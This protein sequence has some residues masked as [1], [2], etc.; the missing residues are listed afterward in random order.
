MLTDARLRALIAVTPDRRIELPDGSIK[1]LILRAGPRA[2]PTWTLRYAVAGAGGVTA[3]GK[4]L[5][6]R[7]FFRI[8]LGTYPTVSLKEARAKASAFLAKA[9]RGEDPLAQI[10]DIATTQKDSVCELA[11][12]FL[13]L[14]VRGRL[15]SAKNTEWVMRE[16]VLPRLGQVRADKLK[17]TDIV[18][19]LNDLARHATPTAAIETR[20]WLSSLFSWSLEK[21]RIATNPLLGVRAPVKS[22]QRERVLS[23]DEARA[24]WRAA[25]AEGYPSGTLVCLLMLTSARLRE[26]A[27]ARLAWLD[28]SQACL[29][30]PGE[31]YKTG[32]A[33]IVPLIPEAM[34]LIEA[35][36]QSVAGDYL[37][38]S[39]GERRPL[40]T[41]TPNALLRI[42]ASADAL[43]GRSLSHWTLHDLR[44]TV[45]THMARLGVDDIVVE[46]VL[47]HRIGG[48]KAVHNRY[49]YL[50]EKRAALTLWARELLGEAASDECHHRSHAVTGA[51]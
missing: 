5:D 26:I 4:E 13:D 30:I 9:A 12:A 14:H 11:S 44:R 33:T 7:K 37:L 15:R 48:V 29:D 24:V 35:M 40:Y 18:A 34:A 51:L 23:L 21:G 17:R 39:D 49:R 43:L 20:K 8:S 3:R 47:G 25:C 42:R 1:G 27:N 10:E 22:K 46:R 2:K 28:R 16:Y 36:P 19:L 38:S 45:A 32:D 50:E 6:G 41:V 31:A